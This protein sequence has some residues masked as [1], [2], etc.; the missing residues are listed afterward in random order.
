L[1]A[2]QELDQLL[3]ALLVGAKVAAMMTGFLTD[4]NATAGT[5]PFTEGQQHGSVL[6][7]GLEPGTIK[8]LPSG[9]DIK[10]STPQASNSAM[11]LAKLTLRS[12][13]AGLGVPEYLLTGDL[14]PACE[15]GLQ[16]AGAVPSK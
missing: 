13:A 6:D 2:L 4:Q 16:N 10:F 12:I 8:V 9:F 15:P 7:G 5:S 3:D 1:V 14:S 11:D